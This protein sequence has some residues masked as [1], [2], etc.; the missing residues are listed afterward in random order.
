M[1]VDFVLGIL[2]FFGINLGERCF[3]FMFHFV[4]FAWNL[5]AHY[6]KFERI[7]VVSRILPVFSF[8]P[9]RRSLPPRSRPG[10][11]R[12][13]RGKQFLQR[14]HHRQRGLPLGKMG[15]HRSLLESFSWKSGIVHEEIVF[16]ECFLGVE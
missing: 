11:C 2:Y 3:G 10:H 14:H 7:S 5:S 1:L 13:L 12:S 16:F 8:F 4:F 15:R 6:M 9:V